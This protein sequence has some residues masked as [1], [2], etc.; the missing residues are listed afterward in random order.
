VQPRSLVVWEALALEVMYL[1]SEVQVTGRRR[2]AALSPSRAAQ[3]ARQLLP[4]ETS[5]SRAALQLAPGHPVLSRSQPR[6]RCLV[7]V[8][9][10]LYLVARVPEVGTT[11][12]P[13]R[14]KAVL[15]VVVLARAE[16]FLLSEGQASAARRPGG[17]LSSQE[18]QVRE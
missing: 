17:L 13:S 7:R 11:V 1:F 9:P 6:V 4:V 12:E 16:T 2:R 14:F 10:F 5:P 8:Q 15:A 18:E 3:A